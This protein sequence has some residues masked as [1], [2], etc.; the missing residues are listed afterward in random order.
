MIAQLSGFPFNYILYLPPVVQQDVTLAIW[1]CPE[2]KQLFLSH[3]L[4]GRILEFIWRTVKRIKIVVRI[5]NVL[6]LCK[7]L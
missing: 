6:W 2:M 4:V 7:S 1:F 5:V 3:F